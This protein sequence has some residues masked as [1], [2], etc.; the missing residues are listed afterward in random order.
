MVKRIDAKLF[1]WKNK[2][3]T[4]L[5][6]LDI[7]KPPLKKMKMTLKQPKSQ[8]TKRKSDARL[9]RSPGIVSICN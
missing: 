6:L 4:L 5:C 7:K 8:K 2:G 3:Y 9:G 1:R